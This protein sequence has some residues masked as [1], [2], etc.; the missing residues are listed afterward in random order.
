MESGAGPEERSCPASVG[1]RG[2]V[3]G[4]S[5]E[6]IGRLGIVMSEVTGVLVNVS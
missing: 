3:R 6:N 2:N 4:Q 5:L 1:S